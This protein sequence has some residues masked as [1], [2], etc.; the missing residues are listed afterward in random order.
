MFTFA[1]VRV[2]WAFTGSYTVLVFRSITV[3]L[4]MLKVGL[5]SDVIGAKVKTSLAVSS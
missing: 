5:P 2:E 4:V 3:P 1:N